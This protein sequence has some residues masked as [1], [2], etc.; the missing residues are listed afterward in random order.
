[1]CNINVSSTSYSNKTFPNLDPKIKT[2][3]MHAED[4]KMWRLYVHQEYPYWVKGR[5]GLLGD[6]AHPMLPDQ[7][8]GYCQAIE[9]A[10]ALGVLFG[11][12]TFFKHIHCRHRRRNR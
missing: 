4:I 12:S 2:L 10:A 6:A 7:S 5:V 9:D 8:Q 3:F 1:L 11:R